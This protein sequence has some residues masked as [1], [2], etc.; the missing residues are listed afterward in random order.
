[1]LINGIR[2]SLELFILIAPIFLDLNRDTPLQTEN[3][4]FRPPTL[5]IEG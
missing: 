2:K 4:I 5:E 3:I 1:M